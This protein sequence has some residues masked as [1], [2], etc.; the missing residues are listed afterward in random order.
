MGALERDDQRELVIFFSFSL[1]KL[2]SFS[3]T[4]YDLQL[5]LCVALGSTVGGVEVE[6]KEHVKK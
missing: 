5:C 1:L 2:L 4:F 3:I 6:G